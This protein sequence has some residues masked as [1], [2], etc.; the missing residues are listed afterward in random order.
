MLECVIKPDGVNSSENWH[1]KDFCS[2]FVYKSPEAAVVRPHIADG[3]RQVRK[4]NNFWH[5][6][7]QKRRR[8]AHGRAEERV[9][10]GATTA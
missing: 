4:A 1:R 8:H 7:R 5:L 3:H 6:Q 10:A 2:G 9:V